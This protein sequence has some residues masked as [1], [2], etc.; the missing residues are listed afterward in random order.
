MRVNLSDRKV[1]R[2]GAVIDLGSRKTC[3]KALCLLA[4]NYP[5]RT[6]KEMLAEDDPESAP[7][8]VSRLRDFLRPLGLH[9][10]R[11]NSVGYVLAERS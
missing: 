2:N 3:W 7:M 4:R 8:T 6:P 10:P 5:A 9:I 1:W 11:P